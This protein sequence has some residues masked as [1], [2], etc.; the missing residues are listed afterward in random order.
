[1]S[2]FETG[3]KN[4]LLHS[5]DGTKISFGTPQDIRVDLRGKETPHPEVLK[6]FADNRKKLEEEKNKQNEFSVPATQPA[7]APST[8]GR[9]AKNAGKAAKTA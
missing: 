5:P 2:D 6:M 7:V 1:M 4:A 8:R 9:K 3:L